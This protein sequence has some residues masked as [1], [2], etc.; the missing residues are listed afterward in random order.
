MR[1]LTARLEFDGPNDDDDQAG[2]H[3]VT[4]TSSGDDGIDAGRAKDYVAR[5]IAIGNLDNLEVTIWDGDTELIEAEDYDAYSSDEGVKEA[6]ASLVSGLM[7]SRK[8]IAECPDHGEFEQD[9]PDS[10]CPTCE[11]EP[12]RMD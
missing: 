2:D 6:K 12:S 11:D 8:P 3:E 9:A 10:P 7:A 5:T 4:I 1:V